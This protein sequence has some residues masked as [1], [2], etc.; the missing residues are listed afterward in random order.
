VVYS[1]GVILHQQNLFIPYAISDYATSFATIP[2]KALLD[3]I[4]HE[5]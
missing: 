5:D 2:L 3:A 4:G 1:C